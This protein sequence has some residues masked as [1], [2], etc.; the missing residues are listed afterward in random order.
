MTEKEAVL[1]DLNYY[2]PRYSPDGPAMAEELLS[3]LAA[4]LGNPERAFSMFEKSYQPN[5]LPPF[6]VIGNRRG[7]KP[8]FCHWCGRHV[9]SCPLWNWWA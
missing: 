6:K 4:R 7:L 9:T 3:V 1:R 5:E 2:E 8:L